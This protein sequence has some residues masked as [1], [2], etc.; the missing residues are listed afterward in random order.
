[1]YCDQIGNVVPNSNKPIKKRLT[2]YPVT[3]LFLKYYDWYLMNWNMYIIL[4][5]RFCLKV[6]TSLGKFIRKLNSE[7]GFW[8][9]KPT[10]Y[11]LNSSE[12]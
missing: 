12:F 4:I 9:L 11:E 1:M 3:S 5:E 6:D 8:S 2:K 10:Q 7:E